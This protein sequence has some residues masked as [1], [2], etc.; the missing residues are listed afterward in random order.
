[1]VVEV[2][3]QRAYIQIHIR[4]RLL[5]GADPF[6]RRDDAHK[7]DLFTAFVLEHLDCGYRR[8]SR[9]QHGIHYEHFPL[10]TVRRQLA[11]VFHRL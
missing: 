4:V 7:M 5:H 1:M 11:V 3:V 10:R 6:R 2:I 8:T 9:S